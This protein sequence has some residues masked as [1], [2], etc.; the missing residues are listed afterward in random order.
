MNEK[1]LKPYSQLKRIMLII[2]PVSGR[3]ISLRFLPDIIRIFTDNDYVVSVFPT[4]KRGD[5]TEFAKLYASEY[6]IVVTIGGDGTL[7]EALTGLILGDHSTPIGYIPSGSTNDF[8]SCHGISSD[9]LTAA[10]NIVNG[11]PRQI[12]IGKFGDKYFSYVSAF[13]AFS[14]L[15]YT[16][17]QNLKNVL[18]HSAYLIDAVK[19]LPKLK[20]YH[21][22]FTDGG[23]TYEGDYIFGAVCNSTSVAGTFTLPSD[24]VDTSDGK[25]EVL[26]VHKPQSLIDWQ[27]ILNGVFTQDYSSYFLDLFQVDSLSIE[28]PSTLDWSL[29]G[30]RGHGKSTIEFEILKKRITLIS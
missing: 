13:G 29:D 2:N 6:D 16:T 15:S 4:G 27:S 7:N 11:T 3:R 25:F 28:A 5:A 9:M 17:S 18:G 23:F 10:M 20:S 26:L 30:E 14:W 1:I 21:L 8:A 24:M 22:K 19:D 12:D